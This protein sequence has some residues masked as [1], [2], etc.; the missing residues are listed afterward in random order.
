MLLQMIGADAPSATVGPLDSSRVR[1]VE[2][3]VG[4]SNEVLAQYRDGSWCVADNC[5][6]CVFCQGP[7]LCHF[8]EGAPAR[9]EHTEG[10]FREL[11]LINGVLW[12]DDLALARLD[13]SEQ[14]WR[15]IDDWSDYFRSISWRPA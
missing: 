1:A 4:P 6:T 15:L 8:E 13:L 9:P 7:A 14:V 12:G 3:Q 11:S 10:P 2:L 5:Y